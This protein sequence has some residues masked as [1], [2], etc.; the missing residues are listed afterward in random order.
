[1]N[2]NEHEYYFRSDKL[3]GFHFLASICEYSCSFVAKMLSRAGQRPQ[4]TKSVST[5]E[6]KTV[7]SFPD[8]VGFCGSEFMAASMI[9]WWRLAR[10]RSR[11]RLILSSSARGSTPWLRSS[12]PR[13]RNLPIGT[14]PVCLSLSV[15]DRRLQIARRVLQSSQLT[16]SDSV[17]VLGRHGGSPCVNTNSGAYV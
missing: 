10:C 8:P 6:L 9:D 2:T 14:A 5:S 7:F 15:S 17:M 12:K 13:P 11:R 1:M 3:F 4:T 16:L